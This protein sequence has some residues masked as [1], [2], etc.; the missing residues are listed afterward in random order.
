MARRF[1]LSRDERVRRSR[2][3]DR[4]FAEGARRRGRLLTV[5]CAPNGLPHARLGV[6]MGRGWR[7]AVARNRARRVVREAFRTR[8]HDI[9][10]GIDVV[11]VPRPAWGEPSVHD[12]A[13]E[14]VRLVREAIE[15][16][17]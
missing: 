17:G 6:A 11:V 7:K 1:G 4:V 5:R 3:F 16:E 14:L 2:D 10:T 8:K 13:D 12:V 15:E 9:P